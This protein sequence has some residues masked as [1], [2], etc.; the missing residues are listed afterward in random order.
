MEMVDDFYVEP[1]YCSEYKNQV[2]CSAMQGSGTA[3]ES[4][5]DPFCIFCSTPVGNEA[6]QKAVESLERA[7]WEEY[8]M[9]KSDFV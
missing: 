6:Y 4:G 1:P 2:T 5:E 8:I 9:F 3:H 7:L